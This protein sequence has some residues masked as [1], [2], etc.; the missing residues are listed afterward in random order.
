MKGAKKPPSPSCV[1]P[2]QRLQPQDVEL[3]VDVPPTFAHEPQPH[4]RRQ[5]ELQQ[6]EV[7]VPVEVPATVPDEP[8]EF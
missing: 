5:Q 4:G 2:E 8:D 3:P 7:F 6:H 1:Y